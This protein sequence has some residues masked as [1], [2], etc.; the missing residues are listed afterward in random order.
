LVDGFVDR[1]KDRDDQSSVASKI[2]DFGK[3]SHGLK[4]Q[5]STVSEKIDIQIRKLDNGIRRFEKRDTDIFTHVVKSLSE[6]NTLRA[7]VLAGEL[8]EIRNVE[9]MLMQAKLA[10]ESISLR[11]NTVSELGDLVTVLAPATYV[12]KSIRSNM[13]S[14]VPEADRELEGIGNL[15]SELACSTNQNVTMPIS[16]G[17]ANAEAEKILEEAELAAAERLRRRLPKVETA[18]SERESAGVKT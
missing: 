6:R 9:K 17:K 12:L 8:A 14:I 1:W 4:H 16:I 10:L 2:K 5:I 7:N 3:P 15:L 18:V 13:A 11:L